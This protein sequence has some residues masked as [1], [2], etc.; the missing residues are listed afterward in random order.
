MSAISHFMTSLLL[1][2]VSSYAAAAVFAGGLFARAQSE[3]DRLANKAAE[4]LRGQS[5][6]D[7][8]DDAQD[9][10]LQK[11]QRKLSFASFEGFEFQRD[12]SLSLGI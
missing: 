9:A 3:H 8:F 1:G 11:W 6:A 2:L 5:F 4:K 7:G 10:L 12:T